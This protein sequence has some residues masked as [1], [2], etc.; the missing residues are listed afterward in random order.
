[1]KKLKDIQNLIQSQSNVV[2]ILDYDDMNKYFAEP[3]ESGK[4][5][6]REFRIL[7][8]FAKSSNIKVFLVTQNQFK[9]EDKLSSKLE[10]VELM[11]LTDELLNELYE[12]YKE[13]YTF[14]YIGSKT[15]IIDKIKSP[16]SF[17]III[18][19]SSAE[20]NNNADIAMSSFKFQQVVLDIN[21]ICL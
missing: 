11:V 8:N 10:N 15:K 13:F 21:N 7:Q 6:D 12:S 18:K 20:S 14:V 9:N 3:A 2:I 16:E 19:N 17:S 4:F 5:T 1:M